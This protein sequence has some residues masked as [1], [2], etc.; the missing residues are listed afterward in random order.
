M[1]RYVCVT[2][3]VAVPAAGLAPTAPAQA[4]DVARGRYLV[5]GIAACGNC[6]T[7]NGPTGKVAGMNLAGGVMEVNRAFRAVAA[8]ITPDRETRIGAWT[9]AE[10]DRAIRSGVSRDGRNLA[11]PMGYGGSRA[12]RRSACALDS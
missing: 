8:N 10:I 1:L 5:E 6:P 11:L 9:D 12:E 2:V 4:G 3:T 7:P